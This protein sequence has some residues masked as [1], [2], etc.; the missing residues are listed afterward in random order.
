[1]ETILEE[2]NIK[3]EKSTEGHFLSIMLKGDIGFSAFRFAYEH[4]LAFAKREN[5]HKIII[6]HI[7]LGKTSL[8]TKTWFAAVMI[9]QL[10]TKLGFRLQVAIMVK[11]TKYI[12]SKTKIIISQFKNISKNVKIAPFEHLEEAYKW[13]EELKI[14]DKSESAEQ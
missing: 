4:L 5:I 2:P 10:F 1:M 8:R 6:N 13:F 9:P 7:A 14:S 12:D 11:P 3:I